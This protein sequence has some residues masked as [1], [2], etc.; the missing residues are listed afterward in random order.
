MTDQSTSKKGTGSLS[1]TRGGTYSL[2]VPLAL[3]NADLILIVLAIAIPIPVIFFVVGARKAYDDIGKGSLGLQLE[4]DMPE[5]IRDSGAG[6]EPVGVRDEEIRQLLEAKAYRQSARGEAPLDVDA[7]L[8]RL[9]GQASA[10]PTAADPGLRVEVR[11]LVIARNERRQRQGK[12]PLDVEA[13][14]ER[15]L[16]ELENLGQ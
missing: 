9:A 8:E 14:V 1:Q 16:R 13:E 2:G 12:E 7:E 11:Q 15:Q 3:S 6:S 4:S 10:P 5:G